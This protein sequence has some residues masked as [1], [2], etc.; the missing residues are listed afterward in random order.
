MRNVSHGPMCGLASSPADFVLR[1]SRPAVWNS[2]TQILWWK[3]TGAPR[4]YSVWPPTVVQSGYDPTPV[5]TLLE[6]VHQPARRRL[7]LTVS[8]RMVDLRQPPPPLVSRPEMSKHDL[9][10]AISKLLNTTTKLRPREEPT[11]GQHNSMIYSRPTASRTIFMFLLQSALR[12]TPCT[13]T[14]V[15]LRTRTRPR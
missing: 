15:K 14:R 9:P 13:P 11:R 2:L 7:A 10:A 12:F 4:F 6:R 8:Y 3:H 5:S 1:T